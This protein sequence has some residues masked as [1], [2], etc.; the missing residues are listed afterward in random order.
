MIIQMFNGWYFFWILVQVAATVGL[1]F[2]LR[3][4]SRNTQ[5][6]VLYGMLIFGLVLHF[7]KMFIAP[8]SVTK[9]VCFVTPGLS[10]SAAQ[11]SQ[12]LVLIPSR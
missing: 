12:T 6:G 3:K 8:Y 9:P 2:A 5:D 10:I 7:L 1:Y 4:A 11:I